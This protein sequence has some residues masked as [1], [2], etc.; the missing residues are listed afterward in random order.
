MET[1]KFMLLDIDYVTRNHK[2][3][4]RLFGK[5]P[6]GR[7]IIAID[8]NFKP[9]IY[10]QPLDF[11]ECINEL[12]ALGLNKIERVHRIDNRKEKEFFKIT[13]NH[14][15]DIP[16]LKKKISNLKSVKDIIE[17]DIQLSHRYLIDNGLFALSEVEARGKVIN[18]SRLDKTLI[19]EILKRPQ[20]VKSSMPE[21]NVLSF[22]IETYSQQGTPQVS[23][24]PIVIIS[25]YSTGGF[26]K[27]FSTKNSSSDFVET[28]PNEVELLNKFNETIKS[29]NPDIIIGY[30]SDKFDFPYLKERAE[31]LGVDL[32]MGV[33]GSQ[34]KF[35]KSPKRAAVIKG[36]IHID[37]YRIVR[38][39]M[40]LNSH[41][42]QNVYM[43]LFRRDKIDIPLD[44][45]YSCWCDDGEKLEN[46]FRYSLEDTKAI[47]EIGEIMLPMIREIAGLVGQSIFEIVR[48]GTGT[49]VKWHLIR[50]AY[51]HG[52]ILPN[53]PGKF[54][55]NVVGGWVSE[56]LQGM[57][58][59]IVYFDFRSLYPSIIIAKNISPETLTKDGTE[60]TC[61]IAPEFGYK[62]KKKPIGFIPSVIKQIL[63]DRTRIKSMMKKATDPREKQILKYRQEALK[64][65][66]ST[67]YGL[68]NHPQYRW[69]SIEASE[70]ITAWG[71]QFLKETMEKAE[72][73]GFRPVYADT[74]GFYAVIEQHELE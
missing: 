61:H 52:Y 54:E 9:Y 23:E 65:I 50:K 62:F 70:A 29:E 53:E 5:L 25:F 11:E 2:P 21:L 14:P 19:F 37:L 74:D 68:F 33:D 46:L 72:E 64:T 28:V 13:L 12:R 26:H 67:F 31:L 71:R 48:R 43:E 27:V 36:R 18:R 16:N 30:N 7:S 8:R 44:Q 32:N 73:H 57:H 56:P 6:D 47:G 41:T 4:V 51:E 38:R 59:N 39:H 34:I 15:R 58:E 20:H 63:D 66:I 69:Y 40:Q 1:K 3:V 55:R 10:A 49:Q 17:H 35:I 60:E 42:L 45:I 24:D 22:K